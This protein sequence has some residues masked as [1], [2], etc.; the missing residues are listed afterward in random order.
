MLRTIIVVGGVSNLALEN[1]SARFWLLG[2]FACWKMRGALW[3]RY[4]HWSDVPRI[5]EPPSE[6]PHCKAFN[7]LSSASSSSS[8]ASQSWGAMVLTEL[9]EYTVFKLE[10]V[11]L[12]VEAAGSSFASSPA[13]SRWNLGC[14]ACLAAIEVTRTASRSGEEGTAASAGES[15]EHLGLSMALKRLICEVKCSVSSERWSMGERVASADL[16]RKA[17]GDGLAAAVASSATNSQKVFF[18]CARAMVAE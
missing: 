1:S 17:V 6:R 12:G 13:P 10:V 16:E 7:C 3:C 2:T 15:E 11:T 8:A 18:T 9:F 5:S 14:Q 4:T